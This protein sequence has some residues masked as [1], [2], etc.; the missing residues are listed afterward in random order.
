MLK[1]AKLPSEFNSRFP[2]ESFD[3]RYK[4]IWL[5][6][7]LEE[8]EIKFTSIKDAQTFQA[9]LHMYRS[10]L[11]K[12][13]DETAVKLYRAKT[14]RKGNILF[15]RPADTAFE[16]ALS[17]FTPSSEDPPLPVSSVPSPSPTTISLED[18]FAE[19]PT[20]PTEE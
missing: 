11:R 13:G 3:P 9:R 5:R 6:A 15:I 17:L 20:T 14:S 7:A 2:L 18:L 8:L 4:T 1:P 19:F 12:S 10:R 16:A